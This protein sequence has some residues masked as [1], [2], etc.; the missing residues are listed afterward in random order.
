M[1]VIIKEH[2]N[3]A[4]RAIL[5]LGKAEPAPKVAEKV[6]ASI[7]ETSFSSPIPGLEEDE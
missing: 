1:N 6:R 3:L 2:V 4:K 7:K 5:G